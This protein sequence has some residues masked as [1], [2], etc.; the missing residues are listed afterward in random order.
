M[1]LPHHTPPDSIQNPDSRPSKRILSLYSRLGNNMDVIKH[2]GEPLVSITMSMVIYGYLI[3]LLVIINISMVIAIVQFSIECQLSF[4]LASAS[5]NALQMHPIEHNVKPC[6][7]SYLQ[8]HS[9]KNQ[10]SFTL[11]ISKH[12]T[13][14]GQ[15]SRIDV[16][17]VTRKTE[18]Y[19]WRFRV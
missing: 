18:T 13:Q 4:S 7:G 2:N 1:L 10:L 14:G 9:S 5:L 15:P 19:S 16:G 6:T 8:A 11:F 3:T 17:S 12:D